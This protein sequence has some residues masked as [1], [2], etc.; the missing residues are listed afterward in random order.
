MA[1]IYPGSIESAAG[2]LVG[3]TKLVETDKPVQLSDQQ[4]SRGSLKS[5]NVVSSHASR[6]NI[7]EGHKFSPLK[8]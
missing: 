1:G 3:A 8:Y 5:I 2:S 7:D 4:N 6:M